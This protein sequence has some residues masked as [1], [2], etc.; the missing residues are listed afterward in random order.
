M[1]EAGNTKPI[2][3]SSP[4]WAFTYLFIGFALW[5]T[6]CIFYYYQYIK[7]YL[8]AG[9]I[10]HIKASGEPRKA[11]IL[12]TE[13]S[14]VK[15]G[16]EELTLELSLKNLSGSEIVIPYVVSDQ[17]P[18]LRRFEPGKTMKMRLDP[19][20]KAPY[21]LPE[22]AVT[23][24]DK[25]RLIPRIVI[26]A[27]I[28]LFSIGYL[29]FSYWL[30]SNGIGWRF[31]HLW[32]PWLTIPGFSLLFAGMFRT[33]ATAFPSTGNIFG[34]SS[35]KLLPYIFKGKLV[36]AKLISAEQTGT[37]INEQPQVRFKL[38]YTDEAGRPYTTTIK[39]IV[40]LLE[41]SSVNKPERMILY[42]PDTPTDAIF[43]DD[44][45]SEEPVATSS[46]DPLFSSN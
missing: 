10:P 13:V 33:I 11:T 30:Q 37:Y 46:S 29:L 42:L 20:L 31:I 40:S 41:L 1:L 5:L 18:E 22:D 7:P 45:I 23:E 21:L 15:K 24:T 4:T 38:S 19:N 28:I 27:V 43:A 8:V 26:L 9:N 36:A 14:K 2:N 32:H 6:L 3:E 44:Y 39:S 17:R 25:A 34:F 35:T 16:I 12:R